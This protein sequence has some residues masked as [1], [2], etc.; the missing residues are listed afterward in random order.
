MS[1]TRNIALE[2]RIMEDIVP[3][4]KELAEYWTGTPWE[5]TILDNTKKL[6]AVTQEHD[7]RAVYPAL[8]HL[9]KKLAEARLAKERVEHESD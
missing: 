3:A 8:G 6:V 9:K 4:A 7:Y 5:R 2:K 1:L